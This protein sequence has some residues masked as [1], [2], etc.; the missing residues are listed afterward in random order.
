[1]EHYVN[2]ILNLL[3]RI[4]Y[5]PSTISQ[6]EAFSSSQNFDLKSLGRGKGVRNF[7]IQNAGR[8]IIIIKSTGQ[9]INSGGS[10]TIIGSHRV[11]DRSFKVDFGDLDPNATDMNVPERKG[12]AWYLVDA[13]K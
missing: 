1:M 7:T 13:K 3:E 9:K 10:F 5:G 4:I 8:R 6:N 2:N 11:C 12:V